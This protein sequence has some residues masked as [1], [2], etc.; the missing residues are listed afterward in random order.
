MCPAPPRPVRFLECPAPPR[1]KMAVPRGCPAPW[2]T[3]R[4][5]PSPALHVTQL[6]SFECWAVTHRAAF[7]GTT[8]GLRVIEV[9]SGVVRMVYR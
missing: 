1:E 5:A 2:P 6:L 3:G 7:M 9:S 4:P 8:A